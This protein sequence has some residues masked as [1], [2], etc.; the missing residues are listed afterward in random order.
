MDNILKITNLRKEYEEFVL[1]DISWDVPKD[2]SQ[3]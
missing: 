1:D 3:D 2:T